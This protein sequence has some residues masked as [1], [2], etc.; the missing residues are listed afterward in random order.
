MEE[1]FKE[2]FQKQQKNLLNRTSGNCDITMPEIKK[3]Q[4]DIN[5][6]KASLEHT[7]TVLEEKVANAE[8]EAEK[9]QRKITELWDYQVDSERLELTVK[10]VVDLEDWSWRNKLRIDGIREKENKTWD[11][12]EQENQSLVKY[13]LG[14]AENVV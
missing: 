12:Y 5:D 7:E 14:I 2:E 4:S 10:K 11:K 13:K 3:F 6:L 1:I 9:L 8:K